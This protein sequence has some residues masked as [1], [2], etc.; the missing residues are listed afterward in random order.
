MDKSRLTGLALRQ[1]EI[2]L[3]LEAIHPRNLHLQPISQLDGA[4]RAAPHDLELLGVE[5]V[6]VILDLGKGNQTAHAQ[7]G[8]IHEESEI[9]QARH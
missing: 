6:K 4:A 7:P 5:A 8:H 2:D 1:S 3:F 9:P